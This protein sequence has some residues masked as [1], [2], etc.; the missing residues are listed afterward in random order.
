M[1]IGFGLFIHF[2]MIGSAMG[3]VRQ[4]R[5]VRYPFRSAPAPLSEGFRQDMSNAKCCEL[6]N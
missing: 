6:L 5:A 4:E 3:Q 1:F 2:G